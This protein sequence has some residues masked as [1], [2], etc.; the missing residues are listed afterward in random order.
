MIYIHVD[1]SAEPRVQ[2]INYLICNVRGLALWSCSLVQA[3]SCNMICKQADVKLSRAE[4]FPLDARSLVR[5]RDGPHHVEHHHGRWVFQI[6][7]R[8]QI[9]GSLLLSSSDN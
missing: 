7:N 8:C 1:R 5:R 6:S 3:R 9:W 4:A 2:V